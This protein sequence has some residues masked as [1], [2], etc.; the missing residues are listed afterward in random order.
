MSEDLWGVLHVFDIAD[1]S[2]CLAEFDFATESLDKASDSRFS[3]D[4]QECL[5]VSTK[6][7][8]AIVTCMY[9]DLFQVIKI[10][11]LV[12]C[13]LSETS[14]RLSVTMLHLRC[15]W[16]NRSNCLT[17]DVT[18]VIF[19]IRSILALRDVR[20]F[21]EHLPFMWGSKPLLFL[22]LEPVFLRL[23]LLFAISRIVT[24]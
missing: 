5:D 24:A 18:V 9:V 17:V 20:M 2:G 22:T 10:W 8:S 19:S 3:E 15:K 14:L 6:T 23:R 7:F 11:I 12:G 13:Q 4:N 1:K 16:N 21:R